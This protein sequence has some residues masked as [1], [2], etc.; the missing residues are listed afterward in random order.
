MRQFSFFDGRKNFKMTMGMRDC[1]KSG[2]IHHIETQ[3]DWAKA[4]GGKND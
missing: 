4:N 1:P 3:I 2:R